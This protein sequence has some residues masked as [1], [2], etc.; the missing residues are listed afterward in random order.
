MIFYNKYVKG[1]VLLTL[2]ALMLLF[3]CACSKTND[4]GSA[5]SSSTADEAE[6][7]SEVVTTIPESEPDE[8]AKYTIGVLLC[9]DNENDKFAYNGFVNAFEHRDFDQ[10]G[11]HHN[12]ILAECKDEKEC[13]AK[14][15]EFVSQNVDL[16]F[17]VGDTASVAAAKSTEVI[18][19]IFCSVSDPME[20]G[21]LTSTSAPDK[22]V[23]GVSDFTPCKEQM[24][25]IKLLYPEAK[26]ISAIYCATDENSILVSNIAQAEAETLGFEY[27][28]YAA[29]NE[30]QIAIT[31]ES[32]AKDGDVIYL[33]EDE[34]TL[35][36]RKTIF[37]FAK[38][39]KVPVFSSTGT[40]IKDGAVATCLPD[41]TEL[42]YDAG[43]LA[44]IVLKGLKPI[45]EIAV[46][47]PRICINYVNEEY[48]DEFPIEEADVTIVSHVGNR[49]VA[50][51]QI[52]VQSQQSAYSDEEYMQKV[53][54]RAHSEMDSIIR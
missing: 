11:F 50:A 41:Y 7:T 53:I 21:L 42:G 33:C 46:E 2:A 18:P 47:Y 28:S 54:S 51:Q 32:A 14:A 52:S 34:L 1:A 3:F 31:V 26:K 30:H 9:G 40:F 38:E 36:E 6:V 22:N 48:I 27:N 19:V 15:Q 35:S 4:N 5:Q 39:K 20:A 44:L 12:I 45:N 25:F 16:I 10:N 29:S 37:K 8:P 24:N 43:E 17:A 49:N 13:K 23:T